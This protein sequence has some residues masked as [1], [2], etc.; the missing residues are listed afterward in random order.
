MMEQKIPNLEADTVVYVKAVAV[1]DL[2]EDL[3]EQVEGLETVYAVHKAD[4]SPIALAASAR[5]AHFLARENN[6]SALTVH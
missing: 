2:P 4:G 3:Q 5:L 6:L 1:S